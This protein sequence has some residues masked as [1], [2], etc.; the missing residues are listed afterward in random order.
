M[1]KGGEGSGSYAVSY[2]RDGTVAFLTD[3]RH[4]VRELGCLALLKFNAQWYPPSPPA[5]SRGGHREISQIVPL[6]WL[7]HCMHSFNRD[8]SY[9]KYQQDYRR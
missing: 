5:I 4:A 6:F 1:G 3:R 7:E 8:T 9:Q 2:G